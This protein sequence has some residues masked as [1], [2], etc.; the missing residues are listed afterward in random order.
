VLIR[1]ECSKRGLAKELGESESNIRRYIALADLPEDGSDWITMWSGEI[2]LVFV[3]LSAPNRPVR[4][5]Q[6]PRVCQLLSHVFAMICSVLQHPDTEKLLTMLVV[7][8][9]FIAKPFVF[10]VRPEGFEPP[11]Y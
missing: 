8:G 6:F 11:A 4:L 10:M 9:C 5:A 2:V 7:R 3:S 1:S